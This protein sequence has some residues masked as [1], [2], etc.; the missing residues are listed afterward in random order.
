[1]AS[2]Q[3]LDIPVRRHVLSS[4]RPFQVV[5][6]GIFGGISQP[7]IGALFAKL[8][9]TTSYEE[10]SA[11]V[12]QAQGSAGLIRFLHLDDDHVLAL[13]PQAHQAGCRLVRLIAG[14]PVTMGQM[15]RHVA[16]AGSYAPVT[17][18]IQ[19]LPDGGTR[20]AYD[21]VASQIAPYHD[22]A[23]S[24]VAQRL[25]TEVLTLLHEVT[26]APASGPA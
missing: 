3:V 21:S 12:R 2:E 13:D 19:E 24:Q 1:M 14:N 5:L 20:V 22:A 18:L 25:D 4:E 9:A 6:D 11:L 17:I 16:D 26:G 7:D 15:T 23:A 8:A 10:C